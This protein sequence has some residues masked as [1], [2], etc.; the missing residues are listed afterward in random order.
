M[1]HSQANRYRLAHTRGVTV[2]D[3]AKAALEILDAARRRTGRRLDEAGYGPRTTPSTAID[4]AP[5]VR[6]H[7][8]PAADG[9]G[10]LAP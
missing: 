7:A 1:S 9:D 6:L 5:G 3:P 10:E 4:V 2:I 8:Y